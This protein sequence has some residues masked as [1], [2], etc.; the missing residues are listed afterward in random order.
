MTE[1]VPLQLA[2]RPVDDLST[3][4]HTPTLSVKRIITKANIPSNM[5]FEKFIDQSKANTPEEIIGFSL[6]YLMLYGGE[7]VVNSSMSKDIL[8]LYNFN[9]SET[10]IAVKM[11]ILEKKG[12]IT[13]LER[14]GS[15]SG[16]ILTQEGME[17]FDDLAPPVESTA[18]GFKISNG[19]ETNQKQTNASEGGIF[20]SHASEDKEGFVEPLARKL[21]SRGLKIWYDDF[22]L[23]VGDSI[24]EEIDKGL[25][26]SDYGIVVLSDAFFQKDWPK[27]E[28]RS[29]IHMNIDKSYNSI[30][31]IWYGIGKDEITE[32]SP[33]LSTRFAIRA[34]DFTIKEIADKIMEETISLN[35]SNIDQN[36]FDPRT[37]D[38][39][40][41]LISSTWSGDKLSQFFE[42]Q[43]LEIDWDS[44]KEGQIQEWVAT[45]P[46]DAKEQGI[47]VDK[48][49]KTAV[50][51]VLKEL[52]QGKEQTI[53]SLLKEFAH[54]QSH[55]GNEDQHSKI[56]SELNS[57]LKYEGVKIRPNGELIQ[58]GSNT[59]NSNR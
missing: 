53:K 48:A 20:I 15:P 12:Y 57:A 38:Y 36:Q 43:D 25:S 30:L 52:N 46:V 6:Y 50:Q 58:L 4:H 49:R 56:M 31:P 41:D 45:F 18:E 34:D 29:L 3:H 7:D 23:S 27:E 17:H 33:L 26:K 21:E 35:K 54:P 9:F 5:G 8:N 59:Q 51:D 24:P 2:D 19:D 37:V 10:S 44:A 13:Y 32:Y 11:K 16:Y 22:Q 28:L 39:I 55:L 40:A 1:P 47:D 14:S 42:M